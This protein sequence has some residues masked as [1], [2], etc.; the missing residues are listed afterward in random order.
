MAGIG[1]VFVLIVTLLLC[2]QAVLADSNASY[3]SYLTAADGYRSALSEFRVARSEYLK[4]KTLTSETVAYQRT[5]TFLYRRNDMVS[6]YLTYLRDKITE[7]PGIPEATKTKYR[8]R[9]TTHLKELTSNSGMTQTVTV[10]AEA[11]SLPGK[12]FEKRF[13]EIRKTMT[14]ASYVLTLGEASAIIA[15]EKAATDALEATI[16]ENESKFTSQKKSSLTYWLTTMRTAI[17]KHEQ[18]V[19]DAVKANDKLDAQKTID[20]DNTQATIRSAITSLKSGFDQTSKQLAELT[21]IVV[22][23]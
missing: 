3:T 8:D 5:T 12:D 10:L 9:I 19:S 21:K 15:R 13:P 17:A 7:S 11:V 6:A 20:A 1:A 2:P 4:Y 22:A 16:N 23:N 18:T 14:Q